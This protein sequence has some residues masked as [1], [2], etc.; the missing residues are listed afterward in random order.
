MQNTGGGG[1]SGAGFP[2]N[3]DGGPGVLMLRYTVPDP[4]A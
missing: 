1:G 4:G 3:V 2:Y